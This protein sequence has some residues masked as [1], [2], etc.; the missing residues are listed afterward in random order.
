MLSLHSILHFLWGILIIIG[1][2]TLHD[3]WLLHSGEFLRLKEMLFQGRQDIKN[4]AREELVSYI[5][6]VTDSSFGDNLEII[7]N[8][9][10]KGAVTELANRVDG[11]DDS[12]DLPSH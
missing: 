7:H 6:S 8:C 3:H 12:E 2:K 11:N 9:G 10:D 5:D 4:A 1:R